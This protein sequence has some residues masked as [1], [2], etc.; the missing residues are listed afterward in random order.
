MS[1]ERR[2]MITMSEEQLE[3]LIERITERLV[4]KLPEM[5]A[6]KVTTK[7]ENRLFMSVGKAVFERGLAMLGLGAIGIAFLFQN[8]IWPFNK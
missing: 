3:K 8:K 1:E 7:L 2:I 6:D 5:T 4:E